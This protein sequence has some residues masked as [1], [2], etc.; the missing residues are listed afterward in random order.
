MKPA[1]SG[2][3]RR[4]RS[5]VAVGASALL[6][7]SLVAA[8]TPASARNIKGNRCDNG[9]FHVLHKGNTI[10]QVKVKQGYYRTYVRRVSCANASS[11]LTSWLS[12]GK[13]TNNYLVASGTRGKQ[14]TMF[15]KGQS[16]PFFQ[17]K[18]VKG[19]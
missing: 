14:S 5:V 15:S 12:T 4:A 1:S 3:A 2:T 8:A 10:N 16:G 17:I 9:L 11:Y 13:T 7:I 19:G 6:G 18:W